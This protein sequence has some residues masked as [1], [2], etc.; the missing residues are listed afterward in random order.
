MVHPAELISARQVLAFQARYPDLSSAALELVAR[1]GAVVE[2]L[3]ALFAER[4]RL[5]GEVREALQERNRVE[6]VI[7]GLVAQLAL[8]FR[9]WRR[10]KGWCRRPR[11]RCG[12]VACRLHARGD[13]GDFGGR[14]APG[15]AP[16]LWPPA[17]L[18]RELTTGSTST[19]RTRRSG[20]GARRR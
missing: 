11:W 6:R 18:I 1:L 9:Y 16:S 5:Q 10:M 17:R 7:R 12:I 2:T 4:D 3:A 14:A 20:R 15:S 8:M 13:G 19:R